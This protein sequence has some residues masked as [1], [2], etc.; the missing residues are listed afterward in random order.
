MTWLDLCFTAGID[1]GLRFFTFLN[2]CLESKGKNGGNRVSEPK[3]DLC[4]LSHSTPE[5][6]DLISLRQGVLG[7][8]NSLTL[9]TGIF[10]L[11]LTVSPG[12]ALVIG[13]WW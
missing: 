13:D 4:L 3:N 1:E 6:D 12:D 2:A 9:R 5:L 8:V 11:N 10:T 7:E